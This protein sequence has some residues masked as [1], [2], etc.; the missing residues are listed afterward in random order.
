M[1]PNSVIFL[2]KDLRAFYRLIPTNTHICNTIYELVV[3]LCKKRFSKLSRNGLRGM[4]I[5]K[6]ILKNVT[7]PKYGQAG[8]EHLV[9]R[10]QP[11]VPN[12]RR[13]RNS[14]VKSLAMILFF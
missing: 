8:G 9:E 6:V 11:A 1:T 13:K 7:F 2:P 5:N 3:L 10:K 14:R 12:P 4:T